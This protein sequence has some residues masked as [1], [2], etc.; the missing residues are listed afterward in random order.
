MSDN[1]DASADRGMAAPM[2]GTLA[3]FDS[4]TQTWEEY[5]EVLEH[6]FEANGLLMQEESGPYC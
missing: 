4:Q 2:L 3:A 6:F 5:C 1:E